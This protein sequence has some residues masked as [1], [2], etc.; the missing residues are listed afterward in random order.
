MSAFKNLPSKRILDL[1]Q[2][3]VNQSTSIRDICRKLNIASSG[4]ASL[5]IL[6][7]IRKRG[8]KVFTNKFPVAPETSFGII[9]TKCSCC[10][11]EYIQILRQGYDLTTKCHRECKPSF[12]LKKKRYR[13]IYR[14]L[15]LQRNSRCVCGETL[16]LEVHHI[17]GNHEN[18]DPSNLRCLCPT[19]HRAM[20]TPILCYD[21]MEL[22]PELRTKHY[23]PTGEFKYITSH[24]NQLHL[25]F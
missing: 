16:L 10:K 8:Y 20:H 9:I 14:K 7:L 22:Y 24:E 17:D 6:G 1:T 11:D 15:G 18:N 4:F 2:E 5:A 21:M 19:H 23:V 12:K 3:I 25:D 13:Y